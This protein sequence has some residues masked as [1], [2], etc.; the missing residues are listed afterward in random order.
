MKFF[1]YTEAGTSITRIPKVD[2][3]K[4]YSPKCYLTGLKYI[5]MSFFAYVLNIFSGTCDPIL[6]I[7][8]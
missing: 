8:D 6:A 3:K 2:R 1:P 4:V 7:A 5:T